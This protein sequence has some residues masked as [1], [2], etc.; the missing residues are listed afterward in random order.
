MKLSCI[1]L[2]VLLSLAPGCSKKESH[3]PW[4]EPGMSRSEVLDIM[5][6]PVRTDTFYHQYE[7]TQKSMSWDQLDSIRRSLTREEGN[8][9]VLGRPVDHSSRSDQYV[10]WY[11]GPVEM[12]TSFTL[13]RVTGK[14]DSLA[15]VWFQF[16]KQRAVVFDART[17]VVKERGFAVVDVTQ[18]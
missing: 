6:S 14:P 1:L 2:A 9:M 3:H 15:K 8:K 11:Y 10:S 17:M 18:L 12:D 7:L 5:G 13:E 4:V 16:K